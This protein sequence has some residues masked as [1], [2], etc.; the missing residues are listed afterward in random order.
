MENEFIPVNT[1]AFKAQF[2][3]FKELVFSY[4]KIAETSLLTSG[5]N[6]Q[7]RYGENKGTL[8]TNGIE[9]RLIVFNPVTHQY[10]IMVP[11]TVGISAPKATTKRTRTEEIAYSGPAKSRRTEEQRGFTSLKRTPV[12][13]TIVMG[14]EGEE[15]GAKIA[16]TT[17]DLLADLLGKWTFG[18]GN[19]K[20]KTKTLM[21][22]LDKDIKYLMSC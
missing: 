10:D 3:N 11:G 14:D 17:E 1:V 18:K 4:P 12:T 2:P 5:E 8:Y 6:I 15:G 21:K 13:S 19:R 9:Y 20:R 22:Q 16:D 7:A